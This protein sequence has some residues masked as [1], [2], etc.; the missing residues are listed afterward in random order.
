MR[1]SITRRRRRLAEV[2]ADG[3]E[4][5]RDQPRAIEIAV[6]LAR[7]V[8]DHQRVRPDVALRD[9]TPAPA[10]SRRAAAA[11]EG[12]R[13]MT[14]RSSASAKPIDG[15]VGLQQQLFDLAPDP[16]GRQIVERKLA[17]ERRRRLVERELEPRRELHRAQHTQ[18][19]VARRSSDRP[20]A[21]A[22]ASR[23]RAAV[24]RIFV[25]VGQRIP[26]DRVDREV[27]A[28]RGLGDRHRRDR[29]GP[30]SPCGRVPASIRGEAARRRSRRR[31]RRAAPACRPESSGRPASTRPSGASSAGSRSCGMPKTSMSMSF[32]GCPRR[33]SRTQP[34]T[35]SARPP[36]R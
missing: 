18:A 34:P 8:D 5:H 19:V 16:L 14:P 26:G 21:A 10:R 2:V 13:S 3:A 6:Q 29:R 32:D 28:S 22:G 25:L 4:H 27:A 12:L 11:P 31:C 1:P 30:R 35:I 9:A 20:R 7:L 24:E 36:A 17:A 33:R 23:S 15:R